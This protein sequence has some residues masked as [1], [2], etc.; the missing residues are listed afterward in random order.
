MNFST[1]N[2]TETQTQHTEDIQSLLDFKDHITPII[3]NNLQA[4]E[5]IK[6]IPTQVSEENVS[7]VMNELLSKHDLEYYWQRQLNESRNGSV[8]NGIPTTLGSVDTDP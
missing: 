6:N 8:F 4:L 3:Q 5:D 7:A 2:I 1:Q